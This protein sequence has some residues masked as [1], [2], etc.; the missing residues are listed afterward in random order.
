MPAA[1]KDFQR[2]LGQL[3]EDFVLRY[4]FGRALLSLEDVSSAISYFKEALRLRP[5]YVWPRLTLAFITLDA[6]DSFSAVRLS[7]EVLAQDGPNIPFDTAGQRPQER[8]FYDEILRVKPD[9]RMVLG[10]L[11]DALKTNG[12]GSDEALA[13]SRLAREQAP[14]AIKR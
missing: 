14:G 13:M 9:T 4:N 10:K 8:P 1:A 7:R 5:D 11:A 3:P 12:V 2:V 6:G